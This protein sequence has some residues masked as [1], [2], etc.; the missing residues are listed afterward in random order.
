MR[1]RLD[2]LLAPKYA[3][4]LN[5]PFQPKPRYGYGLPPHRELTRIIDKN[6]QVYEQLLV[7]FKSYL[8][9]FVGIPLVSGNDVS[10]T[11]PV[12][13]NNYIEGLDPVAL[14]AFLCLKNPKNYL[15]IGS[16]NSTKFARRAIDDHGLQTTIISIDPHPRAEIDE[17]CD[18]VIRHP[19][20]KLDVAMFDE[21]SAGDI[22]FVDNSH[23]AFMNSDATVVF[24]DVLPRLKTGVLVHFHDIFLPND[25]PAK[26]SRR[27]YSEQYL[28]ACYL[29]AE[30][31][32]C[33]ILMPNAFVGGDEQ[34]SILLRPLWEHPQLA[35]VYD[36]A[37]SIMGVPGVSF[38]I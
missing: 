20:E 5:Y 35:K 30:G 26:W 32:K 19:V 33:E 17:I 23:R 34:L 36:H 12:W 4:V 6:R 10:P 9:Y 7:E 21:L 2:K 37:C 11:T 25:Y 31:T 13:L 27:Y 15:E 24:L 28:L 38:W 8:D 1:K 18:R 16:G 29:L 3:I 14:Y 22:L